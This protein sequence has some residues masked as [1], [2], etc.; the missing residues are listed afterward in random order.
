M[1]QLE[2]GQ[3]DIDDSTGCQRQ[4]S[5]CPEEVHG[6]VHIDTD[7]HERQQI[8]KSMYEPGDS[9]LGAA[10]FPRMVDNHFLAY[11]IKPFPLGEQRY[12]TMQLSIEIDTFYHLAAIGF[13]SA[14]EIVELYAS[15]PACEDI[16][17]PGRNRFGQG[18][19]PSFFPPAHQVIPF[20]TLIGH[21]GYFGRIILQISIQRHHIAAPCHLETRLKRC[22][23][24]IVTLQ[25]DRFEHG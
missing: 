8:K 11:P 2:P 3:I 23:F 25:A 20:C 14:I 22:T 17:T 24:A 19:F 18:I 13:K 6:A 4:N 16:E 1:E 9:K 5:E 21:G 15:H 10:I 7:E 12:I